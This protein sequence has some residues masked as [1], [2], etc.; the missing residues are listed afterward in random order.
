[1]ASPLPCVIPSSM[2]Q[3]KRPCLSTNWTFLG[4]LNKTNIRSRY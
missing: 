1:L 3:S 4:D 2:I